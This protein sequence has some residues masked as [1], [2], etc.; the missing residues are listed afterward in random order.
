MRNSNNGNGYNKSSKPKMQGDASS[1]YYLG[2]YKT[3]ANKQGF[4]GTI[5]DR[6]VNAVINKNGELSFFDEDGIV[7]NEKKEGKH[8]EFYVL[9]LYGQ[10][11]VAGLRYS[12]KKKKKYV[13]LT[14][15]KPYNKEDNDDTEEEQDERSVRGSSRSS[16]ADKKSRP[17]QSSGYRNGN[18]FSKKSYTKKTPE[19]YSAQDDSD[20]DDANEDIDF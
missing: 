8:G 11:Y 1:G 9:T 13:K 10:E 2:A 18:F 19:P 7:K 14:E 6:P 5:D 3:Q 12:K 17:A 4:F 20:E 16:I 15:S